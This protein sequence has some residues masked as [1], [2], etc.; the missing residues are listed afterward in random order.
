MA[1]RAGRVTTSPF[2]PGLIVVGTDFYTVPVDLFGTTLEY[3][4]AV[5]KT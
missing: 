5:V 1:S 2:P 3:E 4:R